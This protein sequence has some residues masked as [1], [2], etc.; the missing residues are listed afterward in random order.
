MYVKFLTTS[1]AAVFGC[2]QGDILPLFKGNIWSNQ[3]APFSSAASGTHFKWRYGGSTYNAIGVGSLTTGNIV[4]L[5]PND[6]DHAMFI[7]A[8]RYV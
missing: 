1:G 3:G 8:T 6:T 5:T 2:E 7:S 4:L